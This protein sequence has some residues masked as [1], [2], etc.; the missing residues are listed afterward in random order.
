LPWPICIAK[1]LLG[2]VHEDVKRTFAVAAPTN[3]PLVR[4]ASHSGTCPS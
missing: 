1:S 3:F 4:G 2:M